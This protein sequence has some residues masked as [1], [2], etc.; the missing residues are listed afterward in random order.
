MAWTVSDR[1]V[2]D[3]FQYLNTQ[4]VTMAARKSGM[5]RKTARKYRDMKN[6]P[7]ESNEPRNWRTREDPFVEVWSEVEAQLACEPRLRPKTLFAWLQHTYPGRFEDG[8]VRTL[9]RRVKSWRATQGPPKEV[10]FSQ[11]HHPGRLCASDFTSMNSLNVTIAGQH[12]DHLVYHFVLTYSN[13]ES[14]T[15]CF[16]ESFESLSAGLQHA[17]WELGGVPERHRSDRM[18]SAVNNL[19]ETKEFTRRYQA[20]MAHYGLVMEKTNARKANENGDAESLHRHFKDAVDQ[21]LLLRG[22]RD[23][24][25]REEYASF[26]HQE[27]L[28]FRNAGRGKRLAEEMP[29]LRPLPPRRLES[30][31]R[32][33]V[34]VDSGS[35]IHVHHNVYSVNSR[36]KGERVEVRVYAE[37]LQVWYAQKLQETLPRLRGRSKSR[38]DYRHVIDTLVRK[39]GAFANYRYRADLFP[40]SRFRTAYDVLSGNNASQASSDSI[41]S[42][43]SSDS[44]MSQASSDSAMSQASSDSGMSQADKEYLR[45]LH[46]AAREGETLVDDALRVLL[47]EEQQISFAA[48]ESFVRRRQQAP[49]VT[50]VSVALADLSQFDVLLTNKEVCDEQETKTDGRAQP[51]DRIPEGAALAV[52]AAE[53]RREG[54][55]GRE[56]DALLRGVS[57]G[58]GAHRVRDAQSQSHRAA[59]ASERDTPGEGQDELRP[60]ASAGE[61]GEAVPHALGW[62]VRGSQGERVDFRR[63]RF[64]QDACSCGAGTGT[65]SFG[66]QSAHVYVQ[67]VGAT[68]ACSQT[69]FAFAQDAQATEPLPGVDHRRHRLRAAD[70]GGN[71]SVVHPVGRTL[72]TRQRAADE[73]SGV[74]EVGTDFQGS[75]DDCSSDRPV[76]ASQRHPGAEH[77]ELQ[78]G[79]GQESQAAEGRRGVVGDEAPGGDGGDAVRWAC[80]APLTAL[81]ALASFAPLRKPTVPPE[82]PR[83]FSG[84]EVGTSNCR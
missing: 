13:W 29:L 44:G 81:A 76:G 50:D 11:V 47:D 48:V 21:A 10:F 83:G 52:D 15:I 40:T 3:L 64:G 65:D 32:V 42:Q 24:A 84:S 35:L 63:H 39:P 18:S 27:V 14:V 25:S 68:V 46:L 33:Q 58:T 34:T 17:L 69:R 9:E 6:L 30:C 51:A 61:G 60:E 71:G 38:I 8:Q 1:A 75:H 28:R 23:F 73:Q 36:L 37:H 78:D 62:H 41:M 80:S 56:G 43:V 5:S 67:S 55:A 12:F 45:I 72:R 16:S 79:T 20:L 4:S 31:R 19:S 70:S 22:S 82:N 77:P 74:L 7:S 66:S 49:P 26:L 2:R 59:V 54:S 57:S 53:V